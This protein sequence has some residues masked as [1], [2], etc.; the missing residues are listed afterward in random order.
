MSFLLFNAFNCVLR[1]VIIQLV[2][3]LLLFP[4]HSIDSSIIQHHSIHFIWNHS[5]GSIGTHSIDLIWLSSTIIMPITTRSMAWTNKEYVENTTCVNA[6]GAS[7][8][9][10]PSLD[11]PSVSSS[12]SSS[13]TS[14]SMSLFDD[15]FEI[16]NFQN[17]ELSLVSMSALNSHTLNSSLF[18]RMEL[19]CEDTQ[20]VVK[21]DTTM[22]TVDSRYHNEDARCHIIA[23]GDQLPKC[24]SSTNSNC[25]RS[26]G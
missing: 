1:C 22:S 11:D 18:V 6:G 19:D 17:F 14:S 20:P 10:V 12:S 21:N 15:D 5:I 7:I 2:F 16:S 26:S 23:D 4:N 13:Q 9:S 24:S 8:Y 3:T 25:S